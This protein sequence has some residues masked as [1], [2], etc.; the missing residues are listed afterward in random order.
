M[1]EAGFGLLPRKLQ[2]RASARVFDGV[3]MVAQK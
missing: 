3:T 2:R 1:I